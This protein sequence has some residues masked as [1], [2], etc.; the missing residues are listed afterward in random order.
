MRGRDTLM[1]FD[2]HCHISGDAFDEDRS[3]VLARAAEAGVEA[4]L[5]VG[6]GYGIPHNA[7]AIDLAASHEAI[8]AAVGVHPHEAETL[9]DN[10]RRALS[11]WLDAPDVVA[12]GECGLDYHYMN[13][14]REVQREVFA[15]QLGWAR[16]RDLPVS[17]HVR[18]D[19]PDA[20]G[21]MLD[22][23]N[24][25]IR[26]Q[27]EGVLHC[28]T[29]TL[30]FA[31]EAIQ[32]GFYISFSGILT[33]KRDRGLR[34]VAAGLPLERLMVET[35]APLLSPEGARGKRNEPGRV[36]RVGEVLAQTQGIPVEEVAQ[37]T[38]AN[39]RRLFRVEATGT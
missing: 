22:I 23:W 1:W 26:G 7:R 11:D 6:S 38:T 32:A 29:G 17:I 36:T 14:G 2:S 15:E 34:D 39:A 27:V 4:Y 21:E 8:H 35:D 19:E 33:F 18:G 37:I 31:L 5:A 25:Q 10:A 12:V 20:F 16:E 24:A 3:E 9:D 30:D 28:Y 13:S